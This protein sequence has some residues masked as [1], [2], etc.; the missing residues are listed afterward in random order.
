[1]R[2]VLPARCVALAALLA[3]GGAQAQV[4]AP[5]ELQ[6]LCATIAITPAD[7]KEAA[8]RAE[9]V[10]AGTIP[11]P[12][13][14][15]EAR[16]FARWAWSRG[17]PAGG[18]M[19]YLAFQNDPANQ[20]TR[21]GRVDPAAYRRLAARTLAER[22]EQVEAIEGLGFAAGH[23]YR[24]AGALLAAYFHDTLAPRNVS[25]LGALAGLLLH[26]GERTP[27]IERFAREA[28]ALAREA[29]GT[30]ASPRAFFGAYP[31]AAAAARQGHGELAGGKP[32]EA[33]QLKGVEAGEL[34]GAEFLPLAGP[35]VA[36]SYLVR[37]RWN[38]SWNFAA[39]GQEVPVEV[40][41]EAD[42]WGGSTSTASRRKGAGG[43][44]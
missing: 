14:F 42:G 18:L 10:L 37:G 38:E 7:A 31:D 9:C 36:G 23:G 35:L 25:R 30:Q 41:F 29:P 1:M 43:Q 17:E 27:V 34:Q 4:P 26:G 40:T 22:R 6:R 20:A 13:R 21:G 15:G 39:C 12:D 19:L 3:A 28:D 8:R 24:G 33:V 11:S 5:G 16:T 32:C 44:P 2:K